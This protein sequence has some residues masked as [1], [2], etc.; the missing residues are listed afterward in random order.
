MKP[1]VNKHDVLVGLNST[2]PIA[3]YSCRDYTLSY[4]L[5]HNIPMFIFMKEEIPLKQNP[6]LIIE[7]NEPQLLEWFI[8]IAL[9]VKRMIEIAMGIPLGLIK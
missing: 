5:S 9:Q 3:I 6:Y 8:K 4:Y 1:K 7:A 2:S